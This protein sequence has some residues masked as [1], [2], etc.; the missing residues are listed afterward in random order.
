MKRYITM[1]ILSDLIIEISYG[2]GISVSTKKILLIEM[3]KKKLF[4]RLFLIKK[5]KN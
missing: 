2:S 5:P 4:L 3:I 1:F